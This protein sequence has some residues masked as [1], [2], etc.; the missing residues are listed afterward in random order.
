MAEISHAGDLKRAVSAAVNRGLLGD[1]EREEMEARLTELVLHPEL[2]TYFESGSKVLTERPLLLAEGRTVVPD[3]LVLRGKDAWILD[4][5]TGS[6]E[7]AHQEQIRHYGMI[8]SQMGYEVREM[9]LVYLDNPV[10]V[11]KLA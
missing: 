1:A 9:A 11:M 10:K 3:R 7:P 5:K 4:Y 6:P 8:L 2:E